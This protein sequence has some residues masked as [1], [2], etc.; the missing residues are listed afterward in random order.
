MARVLNHV[1][2]GDEEEAMSRVTV[3][4]S[5][6]LSRSNGLSMNA[7]PKRY[8]VKGNWSAW[9]LA[10]VGLLAVLSPKLFIPL[11]YGK[12]VWGMSIWNGFYV[13][14]IG[15]Y[16]CL[17]LFVMLAKIPYSLER[18]VDGFVV[19][20]LARKVRVELKEVDEVRVVRK[21]MMKDSAKMVA[22]A[23]PGSCRP[24]MGNSQNAYQEVGA[25]K[26]T[27]KLCFPFSICDPF[28][29]CGAD[30][31]WFWGAPGPGREVVIVSVRDSCCGNYVLDLVDTD[32]FLRDNRAN[33]SNVLPKTGAPPQIIGMTK[34]DAKSVPA[35]S[36]VSTTCSASPLGSLASP[37][38]SI[39]SPLA[40]PSDSVT[41]VKAG[42]DEISKEFVELSAEF[43]NSSSGE[44]SPTSPADAKAVFE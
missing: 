22:Q 31:K 30:T 14:F 1:N 26:Q 20:F 41:A 5:G 43:P 28:M 16:T 35:I 36:P 37:L 8:A 17:A 34:E 2:F 42:K 3:M 15:L 7:F 11:F 27:I 6:I 24:C 29:C 44:S 19:H 9:V 38:G 25:P 33:Y 32:G 21:W 13:P 10:A 23:V 18:E 40:S 4:N 39:A 12:D